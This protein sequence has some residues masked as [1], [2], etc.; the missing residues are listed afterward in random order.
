MT[1]EQILDLW[2]PRLGDGVQRPVLVEWVQSYAVIY[3]IKN[4]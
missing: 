4:W 3:A 2:S 1:D